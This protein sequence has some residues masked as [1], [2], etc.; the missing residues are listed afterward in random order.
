MAYS[1]PIW[2]NVTNC[3]Y[4]SSKSYGNRNTGEVEIFVGTSA[5]YSNPFVRHVTTRRDS[6]YGDTVVFTFGYQKFNGKKWSTLKVLQ[7]CW[8]NTKTKQVWYKNPTHLRSK[9]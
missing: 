9:A 4:K 1:Y 6:E 2:N 7:R 3:E 5:T 8:M